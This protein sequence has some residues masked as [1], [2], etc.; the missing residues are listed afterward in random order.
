MLW[1][2]LNNRETAILSW[3]EV[4]SAHLRNL[5]SLCF[6]HRAL[7]FISISRCFERMS[8]LSIQGVYPCGETDQ[9]VVYLNFAKNG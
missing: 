7:I 4:N 1:Q 6:V 3:G 2:L 5:L 9:L 8:L